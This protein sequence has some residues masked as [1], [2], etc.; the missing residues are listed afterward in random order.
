[1]IFKRTPIQRGGAKGEGLHLRSNLGLQG[2]VFPAVPDPRVLHLDVTIGHPSVL[3][4]QVG[5]LAV[6]PPLGCPLF[7][8]IEPNR[9]WILVVWLRIRLD[10]LQMCP[11]QPTCY[12]L[13]SY[14]RPRK[15]KSG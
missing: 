9:P 8:W 11:S 6:G 4:N 7:Q 14:L 5:Q 13:L 10:W 12:E 15:V 3:R 2:T 1:M